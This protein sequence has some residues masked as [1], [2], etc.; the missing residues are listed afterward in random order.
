MDFN[1]RISSAKIEELTSGNQRFSLSIGNHISEAWNMVSSNFGAHALNGLVFFFLGVVAPFMQSG[2]YMGTFKQRTQG[3]AAT[4]IGGLFKGFDYANKIVWHYV[5]SLAMGFGLGILMVIL[6]VPVAVM[7]ESE[8]SIMVFFMFFMYAFMFFLIIMIQAILMYA[9]PLM[10]FSKLD[11]MASIKAS[12]AIFRKNMGTT[13]MLAFAVFGLQLLGVLCCYI[14]AIVTYPIG[15][16][17]MYL[18]A[19]QVFGI[20]EGTN[21]LDETIEHLV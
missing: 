5:V 1:E 8:P 7:A 20:E 2:Y 18:A 16:L 11:G 19:N 12:Y 17:A 4:D 9:V 13:M 10:T 6:M 3:A 15:I 14:G 21:E